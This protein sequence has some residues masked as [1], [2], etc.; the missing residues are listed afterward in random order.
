MS[1]APEGERIETICDLDHGSEEVAAIL[2]GGRFDVEDC[3]A[4]SSCS[5]KVEK[6]DFSAEPPLSVTVYTCR[7]NWI[8]I[9]GITVGAALALFFLVRF[10]RRRLLARV[11]GV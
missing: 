3:G 4:L 9:V 1:G 8:A 2:L 5:H 7:T 6:F 10:I 11:A